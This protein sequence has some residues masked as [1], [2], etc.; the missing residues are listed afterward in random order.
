M[1]GN[2]K[3][4]AQSSNKYINDI[5]VYDNLNKIYTIPINCGFS[6]KIFFLQ[7][8]PRYFGLDANTW[9]KV[10][11]GGTFVSNFLSDSFEY[12]VIELTEKNVK[13][14]FVNSSDT[15]VRASCLGWF[16]TN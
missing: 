10:Y 16:A 8:T 2:Y 14:K 5:N 15:G 3:K 13:I 1:L 9:Q 7:M 4:V 12:E 11:K 6:P